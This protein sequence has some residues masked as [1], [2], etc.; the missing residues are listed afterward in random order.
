MTGRLGEVMRHETVLIRSEPVPVLIF[1]VMP[2]VLMAFVENTFGLFLHFVEGVPAVSGA[3]LAVPGQVTLFAFMST[4]TLG[5]YYLGD[6]SWGTWERSRSLGAS[7]GQ[8]VGGKL[9][10]A[11]VHQLIQMS[12]LLAFGYLAFNLRVAGSIGALALLVAVFGLFVTSYGFLACVFARSQAQFN[13][14]AYLGA[15]LMA[16][17]G[18]A[19]TPFESLPGWVQAIGRF[20]PTHWAVDGFRRII[21]GGGGVSSIAG[22]V[23]ELLAGTAVVTAIALLR[24]DPDER[25]STYA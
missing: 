20:S 22:P 10:V 1:L 17:L 4:A 24:F 5:Y 23:L 25:K 13:A 14:F 16:G 15:L 19:L 8:L 7:N 2:V 11:Y 21:I 3:A 18:G 12:L 6:H 9:S